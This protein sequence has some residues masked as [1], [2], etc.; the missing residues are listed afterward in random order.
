[1]SVGAGLFIGG[2]D[3]MDDW[4]SMFALIPAFLALIAVY[5]IH[6][7]V[8]DGSD[9]GLLSLSSWVFLLFV[10]LVSIL[11]IPV[12]LYHAKSLKPAGGIVLTIIGSIVIFTGFALT[13]ILP[14]C[15]QGEGWALT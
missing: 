6:S 1:M 3:V 14:S 13:Y 4:Y 7:T 2:C 11:G 10:F 8:P 5:G 12:T 15:G 9:P